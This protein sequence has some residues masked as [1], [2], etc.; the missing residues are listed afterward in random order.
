MRKCLVT[1][2]AGFIGSHLVDLLV[3]KGDHVDV[4]D[5]FTTGSKDYLN[6]NTGRVLKLNVKDIRL[7]RE[8]SWCDNYDV[9]F[10]LAAQPRIRPSFSY[11]QH[12]HD[13]NVT[14]TF[15]ALQY[16]RDCS[17]HRS[18]RKNKSNTKFVYASS[19]AVC[20]DPFANPYAFSKKIGEDYCSLFSKIYDIPTVVARIFNVYGPRQIEKGSYASV[21]GIFE[22][23]YRDKEPLTITGDG[24][25]R[26]DFIHVSDVVNGLN[27]LSQEDDA[28]K[29]EVFN[30][31]T[32]KNF[33]I[34]EISDMF[35]GE[36]VYFENRLGEEALET[37]ADYSLMKKKTGWE[38]MF[39]IEEYVES[40]KREN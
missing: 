37:K 29:G 30:L 13:S 38:P 7:S 33:S 40:I 18:K 36:K 28:C 35:G 14:G 5:D 6:E 32:G 22:R 1:G 10:H 3:D 19:S 31:G 20:F 8:L 9:V 39:S 21:T 17:E 27:I 26:R 2:G 15:C 16:T 24:E 4:L 12:T 34:N 11:P 25:Q 23:Q